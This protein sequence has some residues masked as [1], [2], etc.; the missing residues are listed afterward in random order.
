MNF[1]VFWQGCQCHN[2]PVK[3]GS[4]S[5]CNSDFSMWYSGLGM[6]PPDC[7]AGFAGDPHPSGWG[8]IALPEISESL[9]NTG[10]VRISA[11][12]NINVA[13]QLTLPCKMEAK[14]PQKT[15]AETESDGSISLPDGT[16]Y[17]F[18]TSSI[19]TH[20]ASRN[21]QFTEITRYLLKNEAETLVNSIPNSK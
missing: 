13:T 20:W 10:W 17:I 3:R 2:M 12:L 9:A 8:M 4:Q 18:C 5:T 1:V 16:T 21:G 6:I 15:K 19:Y 7:F 14:Y 11:D